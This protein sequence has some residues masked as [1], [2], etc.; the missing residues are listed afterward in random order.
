MNQSLNRNNVQIIPLDSIRDKVPSVFATKPAEHT[1]PNYKFI[2]T[3]DVVNHLQAEGWG[4]I[5]ANQQKVRQAS[6]LEGTKHSLSLMRIGE[7][8]RALTIGGLVPTINLVNSHD[9]SSTFRIVFGMYRLICSNG[10]MVGGAQ[11]AAY[12]L[13]HDSIMADLNAT[14]SRFQS[15][16]TL[17]LERAEKWAQ[18]GLDDLQM[19]ELAMQAA[20][21]RFDD[22]ATELHARAMLQARRGADVPNNLWNVYNRLQENG[23]KGG[24][25]PQGGRHVRSLGNIQAVTDYNTQLF[26]LAD[27]YAIRLL[28]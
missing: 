28:G 6:K 9:W 3:I 1:S 12:T 7:D 16:V 21:I 19:V 11:F 18:I 13:R 26:E 10:L 2:P 23:I 15:S 5:A 25:K 20:R 8:P 17:M 24:V 4:I 27:N 22:K 14:L